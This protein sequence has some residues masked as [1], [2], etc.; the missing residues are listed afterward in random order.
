MKKY[1]G[2]IYERVY[3]DVGNKNAYIITF[4]SDDGPDGE[5]HSE[6]DVY[7]MQGSQ[8]HHLPP[9]LQSVNQRNDSD[10][11][12]IESRELLQYF[13]K[14]TPN[15]STTDESTGTKVSNQ[16]KSVL[17][18]AKKGSNRST[19]FTPEE[20]L[21]V[22]K[23]WMDITNDATIG[24][25]QK[26]GK[27]WERITSKYSELITI[28]NTHRAKQRGSTAIAYS[29]RTRKS[30]MD[31]WTGTIQPAV[32]VFAGICATLPLSSGELKN[33][34]EMNRYYNARIED[35]KERVVQRGI[36][37]APKTFD[38]FMSCYE[39]L[40]DQPKFEQVFPNANLSKRP[41]SDDDV[42]LDNAGSLRSNSKRKM[43]TKPRPSGRDKGKAAKATDLIVEG[44]SDKVHSAMADY[45]TNGRDVGAKDNEWR[46]SIG[47]KMET[48][49]DVSRQLVEHQVMMSAPSVQRD[50]YFSTMHANAMLTADNRRKKL[51]LEKQELESR[52]EE[53]AIKTQILQLDRVELEKRISRDMDMEVVQKEKPCNKGE[54]RATDETKDK[55]RVFSE[56]ADAKGTETLPT[57]WKD[58]L[59]DHIEMFIEMQKLSTEIG[60]RDCCGGKD[61]SMTK[62]EMTPGPQHFCVGCGRNICISCI[63]G[64]MDGGRLDDLYKWY[65]CNL[66]ESVSD[67]LSGSH[68]SHTELSRNTEAKSA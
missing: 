34:K 28:H 54:A 14:K 33:D 7:A 25:Y 26:G 57:N 17:S 55:D 3:D 64:R 24:T 4:A 16:S 20:L 44:L 11:S 6:N 29:M 52:A 5:L 13:S 65:Y 50:S 41:E 2:D 35:Y 27:F 8:A 53:A 68:N 45:A 66:Y 40:Q 31:Q 60:P 49:C 22:S 18:S 10:E 37:K 42:D 32:N 36:R 1:F 51:E 19:T 61:C 62:N 15:K 43:A 67:A 58:A 63:A 12:D 38:R 23:A 56:K 48:M 39:W 59:P 9:S 47:E 46:T 21:M 30:I